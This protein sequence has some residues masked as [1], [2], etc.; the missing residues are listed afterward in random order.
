VFFFGIGA[1]ALLVALTTGPWTMAAALT[2]LGTF[3]SIY[4]PVGIPM[5]VQHAKKPGATIGVNGLAGNLG[6]AAAAL[7]TAF[8]VKWLGWRWAFVVPG[9]A[10]IAL[11]FVFARLTPRESEPPAARS[12]KAS[13]ALPAAA[14][15]RAFAV[16]TVAATANS[17]AF[18]LT[19]NGNSQLLAE[20]MHHIVEDPATLGL[21]LATVYAL[22]SVAQVVVGRLI[23]RISLKRL[24]LTIMLA[25]VPLF[26]LAAQARGWWLYA[27]LTGVMLLIFGAIPF[28]DAMVVRYVDDRMRSRVAGMRLTVSI[29]LSSLAVWLL[30]PAVKAAGFGALMLVMAGIALLTTAVVSWLPGETG[31]TPLPEAAL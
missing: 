14:L 15:A 11:G 13:V 26:V 5:L 8:L 30:G 7:L 10:C 4:H 12:R 1:S 21:L 29:G 22:A 3:A 19:T 31:A 16:M 24:Y 9:L 27:A 20:R 2:L 18:N 28:T 25:Q 17:L 23:D 6:I